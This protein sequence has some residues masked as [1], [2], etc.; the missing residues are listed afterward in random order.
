MDTGDTFWKT[1]FT[2]GHFTEEL[3]GQK[4]HPIMY[5]TSRTAGA[6]EQ[7]HLLSKDTRRENFLVS[8]D[9]EQ[10][11]TLTEYIWTSTYTE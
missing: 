3:K 7:N 6:E 9:G 11:H 5:V 8:C 1:G 4:L 2:E 10:V